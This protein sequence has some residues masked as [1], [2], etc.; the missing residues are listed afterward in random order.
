MRPGS[1]LFYGPVLLGT[2]RLRGRSQTVYRKVVNTHYVQCNRITMKRLERLINLRYKT[3]PFADC[4][5]SKP[6]RPYDNHGDIYIYIYLGPSWY[7]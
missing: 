4:V 6:R 2:G 3:V 1:H 5:Q 7:I